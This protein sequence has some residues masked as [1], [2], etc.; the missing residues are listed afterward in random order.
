VWG[1]NYEVEEILRGSNLIPV[2]LIQAGGKATV[3]L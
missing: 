1:Y 2:E 3:L